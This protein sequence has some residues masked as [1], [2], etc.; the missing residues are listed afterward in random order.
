[1]ALCCSRGQWSSAIQGPS[2]WLLFTEAFEKTEHAHTCPQAGPPSCC[3]GA[4]RKGLYF[5]DPSTTCVSPEMGGRP[6]T[7]VFDG[8]CNKSSRS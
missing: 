2:L 7:Q 8:I 1:M 3:K 4:E 6:L 5:R